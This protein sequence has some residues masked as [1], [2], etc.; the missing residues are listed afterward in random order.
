MI[1]SAEYFDSSY[2]GGRVIFYLSFLTNLL[3]T[4]NIINVIQLNRGTKMSMIRLCIDF[5]YKCSLIKY[6]N[7]QYY[8][9]LLINF[10]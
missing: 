9:R 2:T 3:H 1:M 6:R 10:L 8:H 4:T 5:F 7:F